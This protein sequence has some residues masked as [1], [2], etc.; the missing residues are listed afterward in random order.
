M[1][2]SFSHLFGARLSNLE[3]LI[4]MLPCLQA[5]L[6]AVS[7]TFSLIHCFILREFFIKL[8]EPKILRLVFCY[9]QVVVSLLVST[10]LQIQVAETRNMSQKQKNVKCIPRFNECARK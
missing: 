8:S 2:H 7:R 1:F 5:S 6:S 3:L 9:T 4:F 10:R